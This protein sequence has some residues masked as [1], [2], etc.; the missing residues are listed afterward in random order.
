VYLEVG[1]RRTFA[2]AIDWPGWCRSGKD[3]DAALAALFAYASRYHRALRGS[4]V[5]FRAPKAVSAFRVVERSPGDATTDFGAPGGRPSADAA[6]VDP[7]ELRRLLA[8]LKAAWRTFDAAVKAAHGKE[9]RKGPRG[10]GREVPAI[11]RHLVDADGGYLGRIG[12]KLDAP[13]GL[14][15]AKRLRLSQA[16]ILKALPLAAAGKIPSV[17]P[18]GGVRWSARTFV[19]RLTWHVLDHAWEI[20]D[21][22]V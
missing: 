4:R 10:G 16:A 22:L 8:I 18:R 9:L 2:G 11:V 13:A 6:P 15:P 21:R 20:E 17:G 7:A 1:K 3:E 12:A 19:R 5:E 14:D